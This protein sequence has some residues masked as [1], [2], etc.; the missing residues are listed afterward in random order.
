MEPQWRAFLDAL[1]DLGYVEGQNVAL[2][3]RSAEG[4]EDRLP[5]LAA[6]LVRLP[7]DVIVAVSTPPARAA[8]EATATIPIVILQVSDPVALGLVA[9]LGH[10]GG[11]VTGVTP[12]NVELSG[13]RLELL[14]EGFPG[15][16]RV[17]VVWD[18]S[19]PATTLA[20]R[21]TQVAAETMQLELQSLEVHG[22]DDFEAAFAVASR[23]HAEAL[24]VVDSTLTNVHRARIVDLATR[25]QIPAMYPRR[26]AVDIGGL[27]AYGPD[28][29]EMF[30]R[31]AAY[32]DKL[33]KGA[34]PADP[35]VERP[36]KLDFVVNLRT[37]Q[38]LGL[39]IPPLIL[40]QAAEVIQ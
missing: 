13:K 27:M 1:R 14:K 32:V 8:R 10:P 23:D 34:K 35:P 7:A 3:W 25:S 22:P 16:S 12:I 33:L 21:Q 20:F 29:R 40:Q 17:A 5:E 24:L 36:T 2:E 19:N 37:A 31:G 11:K 9:S 28:S 38:D 6:D 30:R 26:E 15:L 4:Q 18:S 39:A